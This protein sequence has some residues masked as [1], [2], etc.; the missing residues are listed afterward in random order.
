MYKNKRIY[1]LISFIIIFLVILMPTKIY[2]DNQVTPTGN[3]V[4]GSRS[5][6]NSTSG[7]NSSV[8]G[9]NG[10]SG[11][12]EFNSSLGDLSDFKGSADDSQ[13][14]EEKA[15]KILGAIRTMGVTSSVTILMVLGIKY[16]LGSVEEKAEYKKDFIPYI[17]GAILLF[18]GS[19][20]PQILYE[21]SKNI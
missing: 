3:S 13:K 8:G 4:P 6:G 11:E 12:G 14:L 17:I 16:M 1:Y 2:A 5:G 15:G 21:L 20:V 18:S 9:S 19:L 10:G 7:G